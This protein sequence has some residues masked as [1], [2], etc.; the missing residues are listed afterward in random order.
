MQWDLHDMNDQ[1]RDALQVMYEGG[2]DNS[3]SYMYAINDRSNPYVSSWRG[4][5]TSDRK[6]RD[7]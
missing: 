7:N 1:K 5:V 3:L 6:S 4:G 2:L